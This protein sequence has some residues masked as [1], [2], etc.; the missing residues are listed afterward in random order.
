MIFRNSKYLIMEISEGGLNLSNF[1]SIKKYAV[2]VAIVILPLVYSYFYL[3][4]FWDPYSKLEDLPVAVVNQDK[5]TTLNSEQ[6]NV[7]KEIVD[8]LRDDETLNWVITDS[9]DAEDGLNNRRYY[10]QIIIPEN[11]SSNIATVDSSSSNKLKG[12]IIYEPNEKRNYLAGQVLNRV[13]LELKD[14][15]SSKI[16]KEVVDEITNQSKGIPQE[17]EK[18]NDGLTKLYDG[19]ERLVTGLTELKD[20]QAK[21][22]V[23]VL[24]L[25]NGADSSLTGSKS[26]DN[27]ATKLCDGHH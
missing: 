3:D 6:R 15:V 26:L 23:G 7:G 8:E 14:K 16:T 17:L 20:N 25:K 27:R 2:I 21:Y 13:I 19:S 5:G 10:A 9:K 11:F 18:L 1:K 22:N 12:I 4:A 24:A